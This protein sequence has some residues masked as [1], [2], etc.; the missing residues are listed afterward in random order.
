MAKYV[1]S[2]DSSKCIGCYACGVACKQE[3]NLPA[4]VS[5]ITVS[6]EEPKKGVD[7]KLLLD[8]SLLRCM[9]CGKAPCVEACAQKAISRRGDGIILVDKQLCDGCG[10]CIEACPFGAPQINPENGKIEICTLCVDRIDHGLVPACVQS[11]IT[12]ALSFSITT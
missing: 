3:H 10:I 5:R 4:G 9:H 1:I 11:C 7:G 8:F 2:F 6:T 12:D